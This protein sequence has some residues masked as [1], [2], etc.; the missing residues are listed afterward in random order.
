MERWHVLNLLRWKLS[1]SSLNLFDIGSWYGHPGT[2]DRNTQTQ[3]GWSTFI[4][5]DMPLYLWVVSWKSR[6]YM[7]FCLCISLPLPTSPNNK[8]NLFLTTSFLMFFAEDIR[9]PTHTHTHIQRSAW[10]SG[11]SARG[12]PVLLK[13]KASPRR[14]MKE[15]QQCFEHLEHE[16]FDN[17]SHNHWGRRKWVQRGWSKGQKQP[18]F[19]ASPQTSGTIFK[20]NQVTGNVAQKKR[21]RN[22]VALMSRS[23]PNIV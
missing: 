4:M 20:R 6:F 13:G 7:S 16:T 19:V 5:G 18:T 11:F 9:W 23:C 17:S 21:P 3:L 15:T 14:E 10:S 1:S 2:K 22:S 12:A 8:Y